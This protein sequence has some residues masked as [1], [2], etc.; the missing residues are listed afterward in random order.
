MILDGESSASESPASDKAKTTTLKCEHTSSCTLSSNDP[1]SD[2]P[3]KKPPTPTI[4]PIK[5]KRSKAPLPSVHANKV[6]VGNKI[7]QKHEKASSPCDASLD[8]ANAKAEPIPKTPLKA[9]VSSSSSSSD[10]SDS[11]S[12]P[13][14]GSK[15]INAVKVSTAKEPASIALK[16]HLKVT[17]SSQNAKTRVTKK[18][19]VD[20]EGNSVATA[21]VTIPAPKVREQSQATG[22]TGNDPHTT[23]NRFTRLNS[24]K[25]QPSVDNSYVAK[26]CLI[27]SIFHQLGTDIV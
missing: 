26:V 18:R 17:T 1:A 6:K 27:C 13:T 20:A 14:P 9:K 3:K 21:S 24:S 11:G 25:I 5:E 19:R 8:S 7:N 16:S 15:K 12:Q 23:N 4:V 10:D 2:T 22:K